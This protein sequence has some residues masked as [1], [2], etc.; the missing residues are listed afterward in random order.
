MNHVSPVT[1]TSS[2]HRLEAAG[3]LRKAAAAAAETQHVEGDMSSES[4]AV[5]PGAVSGLMIALSWTSF[6]EI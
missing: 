6:P 3:V 5:L 2:R 4:R 1:V